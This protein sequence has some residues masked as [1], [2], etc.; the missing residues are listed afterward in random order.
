MR[1]F[2][3]LLASIVMLPIR[4][5][6]GAILWV[7]HF[8]TP[9]A[10]AADDESAVAAQAAQQAAAQQQRADDQQDARE[11]LQHLRRVLS[12]R[13]RGEQPA[14]EHGCRLPE[15]V[16]RYVGALTMD[17]CRK[18]TGMPTVR[19]RDLL[20]GKEVQGI[21]TPDQIASAPADELAARR[22]ATRQAVKKRVST[23]GIDD[24]LARV[25]QSA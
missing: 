19:L 20:A 25:P 11:V 6:T 10:A 17:E 5:A 23:R 3:A 15:G 24:V 1:R 13:A 8:L 12:A 22:A 21:R 4:L 14:A 18:L 9:P 2:L 16:A 7:G